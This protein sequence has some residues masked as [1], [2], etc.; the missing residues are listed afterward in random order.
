M[1]PLRITL[2]GKLD[3]R[4][5]E[6][7]VGGLEATKTQELLAYLLLY[8]ERAHAREKLAALL[9]EDSSPAQSKSYLRQTLWQ[10]QS[11]LGEDVSLLLVDSQWLQ[12]DGAAPLWLDVDQ[13]E[14]AYAQARG[15]HGAALSAEQ[16]DA[17]RAGIALYGGD[18]L[19]SWYQEWC[20]FERERLQNLY[21]AM[22]EKLLGYCEAHGE[23]DDGVGYAACI[24]RCDPAHERTY[25]RLMRLH[26][27]A[28]DRTLALR[29]YERCAAA[30]AREL[31]VAP[32]RSTVA[33]WEQIRADR[34]PDP[35]AAAADAAAGSG[36][37]SAG[38]SVALSDLLA[39]LLRVQ[40]LLHDAQSE[41]V[42]DIAVVRSALRRRC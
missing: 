14:R 10:L 3:V 15:V 39:R 20:L 30:L 4:E 11:G 17:L 16:A 36:S 27:L 23:S 8:R 6:Q 9:W 40:Q 33:L 31:G 25:R 13:F 41:V 38:D 18:L 2:F 35:E 22:L 21:L 19:E 12:I 7:P 37:G 34:F 24:L 5:G 26:A 28:G 29:A 32:A 42:R 1:A